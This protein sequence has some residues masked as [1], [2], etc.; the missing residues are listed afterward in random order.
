[1]DASVFLAKLLGP[2]L[3]VVGAGLL[4]NRAAYQAAAEEVLKTRS[5][6]YLFGLIAFLGGLAV[7]LTHNVWEW[8]WPVIITVLG[9]FMLIRGTLRIVIP[10]QVGDLASKI[11]ARTPNLLPVSGVILVALGAILVWMGYGGA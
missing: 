3:V 6:L 5:L 8:R 2:A 7:V 11:L 10:Q 9:W 4:L 1:M